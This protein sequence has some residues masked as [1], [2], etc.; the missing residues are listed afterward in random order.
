MSGPESNY[1]LYIQGEI[2]KR[3][4]DWKAGGQ[5]GEPPAIPKE[6]QVAIDAR[7]GFRESL[8]QGTRFDPEHRLF[9]EG[10]V[11]G[12]RGY[13]DY[14]D[15]PR[16]NLIN[17][18]SVTDP[19]GSMAAQKRKELA[20]SPDVDLMG[21]KGPS[22]M[23]DAQK[24][25]LDSN[26]AASADKSAQNQASKQWGQ[27]NL[28]L[29]SGESGLRAQRGLDRGY[30]QRL[31][32]ITGSDVQQIAADQKTQSKRQ[33]KALLDDIKTQSRFTARADDI[34]NRAVGSDLSNRYRELSDLSDFRFKRDAE[35]AALN[36]YLSAIK[37]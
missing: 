16:M 34:H 22:H 32:D 24:R 17:Q 19:S 27:S 7:P 3:I 8:F 6:W 13:F 30:G 23:A 5:K 35:K 36:K 29:L 20:M 14:G 4:D 28:N 15:D 11:E 33:R 18:I 37:D 25:L 21:Y 10:R 26:Q 2:K 9:N 12:S 1:Y 31:S